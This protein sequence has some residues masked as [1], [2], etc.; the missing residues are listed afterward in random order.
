MRTT[1]I[2]R[3]SPFQRAK[4]EQ[5]EREEK[6]QRLKINGADKLTKQIITPMSLLL[7]LDL[8]KMQPQP[9]HSLVR[10]IKA[11]PNQHESTTKR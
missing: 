5:I 6:K 7:H 4:Q 1:Q 3:G 11:N 8:Q 9:C 10:Y 2:Y